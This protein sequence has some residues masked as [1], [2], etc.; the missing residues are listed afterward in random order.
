MKLELEAFFFSGSL[1]CIPR[2]F[3]RTWFRIV[4]PDPRRRRRVEAV[5]ASADEDE[6]DGRPAKR[7]RTINELWGGKVPVARWRSGW[8]EG[9]R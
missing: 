7:Q 5:A 2:V 4:C 3:I 1:K 6:E 9:V 8:A